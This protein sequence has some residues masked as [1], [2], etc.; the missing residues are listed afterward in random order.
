M[1]ELE[2]DLRA[3]VRNGFLHFSLTKLWDGPDW[4]CS[5]RTVSTTAVQ[6][7]VAKDPVEALSKAL[8]SGTRA[9]KAIVAEKPRRRDAEDLA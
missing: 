7:V 8:R 4:E 1:S 9:E 6:N 3:A 2:T 5:Y